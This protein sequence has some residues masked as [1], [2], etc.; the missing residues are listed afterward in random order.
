MATTLDAIRMRV[1]SVLCRQPFVFAESADPDSFAC[2]PQSNIDGVFRI[3][4]RSGRVVGGMNFSSVNI[5]QLDIWVARQHVGG[6]TN[7]TRRTLLNDMHS[8]TAAV[9]RDGATGGGDYSVDDSRAFVLQQP[10][11]ADY[12]VLRITLPVN[13]EATL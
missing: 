8:I 7:V 4:G 11:A 10:K 9:T 12:A 3:D 2:N 6:D 5:D 13:Y 1:S